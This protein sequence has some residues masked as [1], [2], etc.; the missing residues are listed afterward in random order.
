MTIESIKDFAAILNE[1]VAEMGPDYPADKEWPVDLPAEDWRTLENLLGD[2]SRTAPAEYERQEAICTEAAM[3]QWER[4]L[5]RPDLSEKD[6]VRGAIEVYKRQA[7]AFTIMPAAQERNVFGEPFAAMTTDCTGC[8]H[9]SRDV[10][11]IEAIAAAGS[12]GPT[13]VIYLYTTPARQ[14]HVRGTEAAIRSAGLKARDELLERMADG[15]TVDNDLA[16]YMNR[17]ID[18]CV[19]AALASEGPAE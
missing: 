10:A 15:G 16:D 9:M 3:S 13:E 11:N 1:Q 17:I 12:E 8:E 18:A 6:R 4:S 19:R 2:N 7:F 5:K 14:S